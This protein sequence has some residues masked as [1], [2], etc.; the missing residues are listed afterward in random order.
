MLEHRLERRLIREVLSA[1][2]AS[3]HPQPV[4]IVRQLHR[5][6][7]REWLG[8]TTLA[9]MRRIPRLASPMSSRLW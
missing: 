6:C 8:W 5:R 2:P 4:I 7:S 1:S 9:S 3:M